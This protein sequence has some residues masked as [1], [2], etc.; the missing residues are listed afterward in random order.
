VTC[1]ARP[2]RLLRGSGVRSLLALGFLI[3]GPKASQ[4][5]RSLAWRIEATIPKMWTD[6]LI[7]GV[8]PF[9]VPA[10]DLAIVKI[11]KKPVHEQK[12]A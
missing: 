9:T 4:A 2:E 8:I 7:P 12:T 3:Y 10:K 1:A 5:T 11:D 6:W